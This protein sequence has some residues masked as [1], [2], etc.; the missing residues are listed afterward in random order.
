MTDH[1]Y[2]RLFGLSLGAGL[3]LAYGLV[4]QLINRVFL[5]GIPLHQ[6]PFGPL[7][8]ILLCLGVGALLGLVTAWPA[9]LYL[10]ILA[11]CAAG[12]LLILLSVMLAGIGL[13]L[14]AAKATLMLFIFLP[15]A[16]LIALPIGLHRWAVE[17]QMDLRPDRWPEGQEGRP[18]RLAA[19]RALPTLFLLFLVVGVG[20]LSL[21]PK[22]GRV[23]VARME[24]IVQAG[25]DAAD[26]AALPAEFEGEKVQAL[27]VDGYPERA[28]G[29]Y[30]LDYEGSELG[31][32]GIP[33]PLGSELSQSAVVARF[34]NGWRFVCLFITATADARCAPFYLEL[35][36]PEELGY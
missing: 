5:W 34:D 19:R 4:S 33:H 7:G 2:R 3:G 36:S 35:I 18:D 24:A 9:N 8:N 12:A 25:L 21:Y 20:V 29:R 28:K 1:A 14:L 23:A 10:G 31:R 13:S 32:F 15:V 11:G 22:R 6:P 27:K 26:Q 30:N 17:K 16:A